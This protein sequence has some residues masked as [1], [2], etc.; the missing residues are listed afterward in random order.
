[1]FNVIPWV[2][3]RLN[4]GE[5]HNYC[6]VT[7]L[8]FLVSFIVQNDHIIIFLTALDLVTIIFI[9]KIVHT[10]HFYDPIEEINITKNQ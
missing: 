5:F 9:A 1:M 7:E 8:R 10:C 4:V 6:K 2:P 3:N